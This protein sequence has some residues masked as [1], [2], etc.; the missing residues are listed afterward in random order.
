LAALSLY[1][2]EGASGMPV[3]SPTGPGGVAQL[4][5]PTGGYLI[6]YPFVAALVGYIFQ[7]GKQ[8]FARA[9]FA[10]ILGEILL[11]TCG[12]SWLYTMTHSLAQA[13]SFGLYW[14]IFA[15]IIKVMFAAGAVK[16]WLRLFPR[17]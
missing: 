2:I 17:A 1:L 6:A 10:S 16:G 7:R 8:T 5:G 13:I 3:F 11:F 9:A 14:F 15:E 4:I 12:I